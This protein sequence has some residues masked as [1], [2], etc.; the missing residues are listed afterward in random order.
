MTRPPLHRRI[1]VRAGMAVALLVL[2]V[3]LASLP[4]WQ[5]YAELLHP[6]WFSEEALRD[7]MARLEQTG[8][9]DWITPEGRRTLLLES[10]GFAALLALAAAWIVSRLATRRLALLAAEAAGPVDAERL[11]GPFPAAGDDEVAAL[12]DA[13][14]AMRARIAEL[15][16]QLEG[17]DAARREWIAQVSHDLRTPVG[18]L[19]VGLDRLAG[20]GDD[21]P[22]RAE[23]REL[24]DAA[25]LDVRRIAALSE[26][27]LEL[28]RL[29]AGDELALDDVPPG[30]LLAQTVEVLRPVAVDRGVALAAEA[31]RDLP[32]LRADGRRLARALEN[33]ALNSLQHA[34]SRVELRAEVRGAEL[35]YTV[36]DDGPGFPDAD[37][38]LG[39]DA[40][41]TRRT[42][43]D[44]AG[45]G[46]RVVARV[47]AAHGGSAGVRN[48]PSGGAEA[49][50][51]LPLARAVDAQTSP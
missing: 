26:D 20:L 50:L 27:L 51:T 28:G 38:E 39:L 49:W 12:A 8:E 47:A 43:A 23:R 31:A 36:E 22:A 14:N 44:S 3:D 45:L 5:G 48:R 17:R 35:R 24:L 13:M 6:E 16:G 1:G 4:L 18:A 2:V 21:K 11:P 25:R 7:A 41:R 40:L 32:I 9:L 42:R 30:E 19:S 46:L 15:L 29:E 37:D 10:V 34:R 33:L